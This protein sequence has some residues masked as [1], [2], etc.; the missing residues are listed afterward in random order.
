MLMCA[1][2][3]TAQ[4]TV[5]DQMVQ[6]EELPLIDGVSTTREFPLKR[7][8]RS[9]DNPFV[10]NFLG[11][12][13]EDHKSALL[14]ATQI[15]ADAITIEGPIQIRARLKEMTG[16]AIAYSSV[17]LVTLPD[18]SEVVVS[19]ALA[20]HI[21]GSDVNPGPEMTIEFNSNSNWYTQVNTN[22]L[23]GSGKLDFISAVL[24]EICHGM[25]FFGSATVSG[26]IGLSDQS[27]MNE[28]YT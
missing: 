4:S 19:G 21:A 20:N 18:G 2:S 13:P 23:A 6:I 22:E 11:T 9:G 1:P 3:L 24:H 12:W 8:G 26:V 5:P 25:G 28:S 14:E 15:W 7:F 17:Q 10:V 16:L 27:L